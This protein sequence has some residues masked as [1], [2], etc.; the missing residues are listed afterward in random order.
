MAASADALPGNSLPVICRPGERRRVGA[1]PP[2]E[3]LTLSAKLKKTLYF[4]PVGTQALSEEAAAVA[5][6]RMRTRC[7]SLVVRVPEDTAGGP[8][9]C[10]D[11]DDRWPSPSPWRALVFQ[12]A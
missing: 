10:R 9:A 2:F 5:P 6:V 11:S 4:S 12:V 1:S 8:R 3:T 7:G